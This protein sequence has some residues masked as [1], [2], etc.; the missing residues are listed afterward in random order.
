MIIDSL[1]E[2]CDAIA[3]NTGAAGTYL[4]GSQIPLSQA[5]DIGNGSSLYLVISVDTAITAAGTGT[6]QFKLSS[7]AT[8]AI[9]TTGAASDHIVTKAFATSTG[10]IAAGTIL[11]CQ[12]LPR[13]GSTAYELFL[14]ILQITGTEAITAG[15]INAFLTVDPPAMKAYT[16][17]T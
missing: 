12:E 3:L 10:T 9:A 15:K 14:G 6:L 16:D 17:Y 13:E 7:D 4:I 5:R 11:C 1:L 2:M 8:A